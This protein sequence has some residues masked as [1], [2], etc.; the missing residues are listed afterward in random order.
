MVP[1]VMTVSIGC[2]GV[3]RSAKVG[4][5]G[6]VNFITAVAY[7]FCLSLTTAF[8]QPGASTLA[9]L[10]KPVAKQVVNKKFRNND[11]IR[12]PRKRHFSI[13]W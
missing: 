1:Q 5:P 9:N 11:C 6:L 13:S 12:A 8:T 2:M 10:C 7:H 4:A 3:Q